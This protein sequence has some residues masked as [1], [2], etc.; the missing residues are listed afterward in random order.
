MVAEKQVLDALRTVIDPDLG[1]DIVSLGFVKNLRIDG[2]TVAFVV[3]LTT[4][5]CP[6]K[7]MFRAQ[8][9]QAVRALPGVRCVHV[10]LSAKAPKRS[11]HED[12]G[13]LGAVDA[14]L[15]VSSCKGGVGKSTVAAHLARA[16]QRQ[17]LAV[18]LLDA[19]IYGPSVPT[20]FNLHQPQMYAHEGHVLP[21][22]CDGLKIMSL[23]FLWGDAPAVL[24]GPV[25]SQYIRQILFQTEWGRLDYLIIDMPPGT[26]D[27]QL[28]IV[29][30]VA[31][32]GAVIVTTP[33]ALSLVDVTRGIIMFE[34]VNVPVLG[35]V[36]NMSYFL[37]D[38]CGKKHHLFGTAGHSL[39]NRF[40]IPMLAELP[41]LKGISD[42]QG[43]QAK[44][45]L[46]AFR[47]LAENIH[48]QVGI[49]R[50]EKPKTPTVTIA[51]HA[52][53]VTW[54]DGT[55]SML[56]NR[57]VRAA[58][59]CAQCVDELSGKPLLDASRIPEDIAALELQP[60]GNYA[61]AITWSDGHSTGIF[62]WE[63]LRSLSA[64]Q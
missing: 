45:V 33:Q 15:A 62:S 14:I 8:C 19:D 2:G 46:D 56:P 61:V 24:R 35:L 5:A 64:K 47:L 52:L 50:T 13:V 27:I 6:L 49:G 16:M 1:Q 54:P 32:D 53:C 55:E 3:E 22:E 31:L 23:G 29:Q 43:D 38:E 57:A 59:R 63:C 60:L 42:V 26:G 30:Q 7:Q 48:R 40:G 17:G 39:E 9:E 37:C 28:T 12:V 11:G 25:V 36:E 20:L 51:P 4:P 58:C 10:T 44:G 18:G 34:K 21:V 41:L